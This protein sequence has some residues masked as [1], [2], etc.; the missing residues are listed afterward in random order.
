MRAFLVMMIPFFIV[1]GAI[2][3]GLYWLGGGFEDCQTTLVVTC[4]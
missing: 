1:F 4:P 3:L 2:C